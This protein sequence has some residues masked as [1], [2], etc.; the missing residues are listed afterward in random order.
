MN[1]KQPDV[2]TNPRGILSMEDFIKPKKEN[3]PK[4]KSKS[5]GSVLDRINKMVR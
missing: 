5:K 1:K 2:K 4:Q 3:N